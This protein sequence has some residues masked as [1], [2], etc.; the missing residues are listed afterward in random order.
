MF[1][2]LFIFYLFQHFFVILIIKQNLS[3]NIKYMIFLLLFECHT[4]RDEIFLKEKKIGM[5]FPNILYRFFLHFPPVMY[6]NEM[7]NYQIFYTGKILIISFR[8]AIGFLS[9]F[10]KRNWAEIL[11]TVLR[12]EKNSY[13]LLP[14]LFGWSA[15]NWKINFNHFPARRI[16]TTSN[17]K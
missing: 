5:L 10:L 14:Q 16:Q 2:F 1:N 8:I 7:I 9:E 17:F 4:H 12:T 13:Y 15:N 3:C 11:W 6:I